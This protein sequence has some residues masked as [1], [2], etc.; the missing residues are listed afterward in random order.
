ME[1]TKAFNTKKEIDTFKKQY[2]N[3][4]IEV[5]VISNLLQPSYSSKSQHIKD[6]CSFWFP[7]NSIHEKLLVELRM[8]IAMYEN[9]VMNENFGKHDF[10]FMGNRQYKNYILRFD[11]LIIV[12]PQ[13][14]SVVLND[15]EPQYDKLVAFEN[16]F[17]QM[18]FD[19]MCRHIDSTNPNEKEDQQF[20]DSLK[21]AKIIDENNQIDFQYMAKNILNNQNVLSVKRKM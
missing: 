15:D 20:V 5:E 1:I 3:E 14:R 8:R 12:A 16:A 19:G 7:E 2:S 4:E 13:K 21:A 11:D 17:T 6:Y 10:T 18:V 9:A